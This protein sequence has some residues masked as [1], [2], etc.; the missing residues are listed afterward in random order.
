VRLASPASAADEKISIVFINSI[1]VKRDAISN[2][3]CDRVRFASSNYKFFKY[4][5][6]C[7]TTDYPH[8]NVELIHNVSDIVKSREFLEAD[9]IVIEFGV[10]HDLFD[11]VLC[12]TKGAKIVSY[13][14][15][16]SSWLFEPGPKRQLCERSE[17]QSWNLSFSDFVVCN[18]KFTLE[19]ALTYGVD[20]TKAAIIA[21][22]VQVFGRPGMT[23]S[24]TQPLTM[25]FVG[26]LVPQKGILDLLKALELISTTGLPQWRL[27]VV[28]AMKFSD[29]GYVNQLQDEIYRA[30]LTDFVHFLGE[31]SEAEIGA[32]FAEAD[33]VV[34]P[35]YHEGFGVPVIEGLA[36]HCVVVCS[37]AGSLPEVAGEFG[38][39][40]KCGDHRDLARKLL[41]VINDLRPLRGSAKYRVGSRVLSETEY[42]EAADRYVKPFLPEAAVNAFFDIVRKLVAERRAATA[43]IAV[44]E[45]ELV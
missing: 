9:I 43:A 44:S 11:L 1:F 45:A 20:Q 29:P 10:Y 17:L 41:R 23:K 4:K 8:L 24:K 26:R 2:T 33:I 36:S 12:E 25:L 32:Q 13:H 42:G 34:M 37:D 31:L 16:T 28:G 27:N 30:N 18:S 19:E 35:S 21:P 22:S 5:V 6:Y 15:V 7:Y 14:N 39:I 40:F 38:H 3:I